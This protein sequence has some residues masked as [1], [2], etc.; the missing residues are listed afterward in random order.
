MTSSTAIMNS[1]SLVESLAGG[2]G[3]LRHLGCFIASTSD[4]VLHLPVP[5]I[6]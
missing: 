2:K 6:G 3:I 1:V 4:R 5:A